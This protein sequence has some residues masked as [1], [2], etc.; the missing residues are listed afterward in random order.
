VVLF[1]AAMA[2]H[3]GMAVLFGMSGS[4]SRPQRTRGFSRGGIPLPLIEDV[5]PGLLGSVDPQDEAAVAIASMSLSAISDE[6]ES[7]LAQVAGLLT[8][9]H[10]AGSAAEDVS[11][12]DAGDIADKERRHEA[13][14]AAGTAEAAAAASTGVAAQGLA[15]AASDSG[16]GRTNIS[17]FQGYNASIAGRNRSSLGT[18]NA[19]AGGGEAE[20]SNSEAAALL[21][22][23]AALQS[24]CRD[25][26]P[27]PCT[28]AGCPSRLVGCA[29]LAGS[30]EREF[31]TVFD[32][33]PSLA[34]EG[35]QIYELCPL[36]CQRCGAGAMSREE[37]LA[38]IGFPGTGVGMGGQFG[39]DSSLS[40][41]DECNPGANSGADSNSSAGANASSA[42]NSSVGCRGGRGVWGAIWDSKPPV[43]EDANYR[44]PTT[45]RGY[46]QMTDATSWTRLE[47]K[48]VNGCLRYFK[49]RCPILI[50]GGWTSP[51]PHP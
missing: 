33:L 8:G 25:H 36:T 37:V 46:A 50:L 45:V 49:V 13:A 20:E 21:A 24:S 4:S 10:A 18:G 2:A 16:E 22:T 28:E 38:G 14:A 29:V 32:Q 30:C 19:S 17:S 7:V 51:P 3:A 40:L 47:K 26:A 5:D 42:S 48:D 12:A 35:M 34:M 9:D 1:L 31:E 41:L 23:A 11:G 39:Q 43:G 15:A 6:V 27:F 44:A